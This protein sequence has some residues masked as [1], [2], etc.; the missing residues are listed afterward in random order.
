MGIAGTGKTL[1][2]QGLA[3]YFCRLGFR[4]AVFAPANSNCDHSNKEMDQQLAQ[5]SALQTGDSAWMK[6]I[7]AHRL[8][9]SSRNIG[10]RQMSVDQAR[11]RRVGHTGGNVSDVQG[12]EFRIRSVKDQKTGSHDFGL[13]QAVIDEADKRELYL[14]R[15][16]KHSGLIVGVWDV[17]RRHLANSRDGTTNWNNRFAIEEY[18]EAYQ[19]CKDHVIALTDIMVTTT[20]N[21]RAKEMIGSWAMAEKDFPEVGIKCKGYIILIDEAAKDQEINIWNA[22]VAMEERVVGAFLFGDDR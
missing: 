3:M 16:L 13:E 10:F 14:L 2:Q 12:L 11:H 19:K 9:S 21:A 22:I 5:S 17:F 18:E 7:R 15:K 4:V 8:F 6:Q 1:I 20:G